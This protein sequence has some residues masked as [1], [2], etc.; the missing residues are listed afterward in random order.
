MSN[1]AEISDA[2]RDKLVAAACEARQRAYAPYSHYLVGAAIL[3]ADGRMFTGVN[4][5]NASYGASS[6]AERTAIFSAVTAGAREVVAVAV[7][8]ENGVT[9]CGICRQVLAEFAGPAGEMAVWL[10]DAE[11]N[12]R[13]TTLAALLPEAFGPEH[14]A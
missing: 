13:E 9:P 7:C 11:G 1:R 5:E 8:T 14:L 10:A 12:L 2:I 4:V 3:T 6:C